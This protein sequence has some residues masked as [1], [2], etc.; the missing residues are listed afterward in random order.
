MEGAAVDWTAILVGW[1]PS[2]GG[3][4]VALAL[5]LVPLVIYQSRAISGAQREAARLTGRGMCQVGEAVDRLADAQH[6]SARQ[7]GTLRQAYQAGPAEYALQKL[8]LLDGGYTDAEREGLRRQVE[9]AR[10]AMADPAIWDTAEPR[11]TGEE[12]RIARK[13]RDLENRACYSSDRGE[14]DRAQSELTALRRTI[15]PG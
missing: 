10:A 6:A 4:V 11:V 9:D 13:L 3:V 1:G 14:R 5:I 2:V 12:A 8:H 15:E 7:I